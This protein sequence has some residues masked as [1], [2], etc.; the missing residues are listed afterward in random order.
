MR[1]EPVDPDQP[2]K[3]FSICRASPGKGGRELPPL[4]A[5]GDQA[6]SYQ[7]EGLKINASNFTMRIL[8]TA[9]SCSIFCS[10][11]KSGSGGVSRRTN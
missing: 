9:L 2:L 6:G 8:S 1:G 5:A 10:A 7:F 3:R 4:V 11:L